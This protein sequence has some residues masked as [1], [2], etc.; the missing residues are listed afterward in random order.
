MEDQKLLS[1]KKAAK[2]LGVSERTIQRYRRDGILVPDQLGKNN[3]VFYSKEQ[4]IKVVT[5]LLA[6]GD[7]LIKFRPQVVTSYQQVVTS[8]ERAKKG[9]SIR[10][11]PAKKLVMVN[12]KLTKELFRHTPEEYLA[13]FEEGGE[14]VEVK[15]FPKVGEIITPYWLELIDE[16]TDKTPL[17]MF[18]KAVF[19]ACVSE[20][21]IGNRR[22]TDGIIFRHITGKPRGSNAQPS[23]AMRELILYY[24][25][26]MMCTVLRVNMTEVCKYL[27][28]NNGEPLILNAP[29]LP[30]KYVEEVINGQESR[31]VIYF[32]DESPLLTIA[33]VKNNQFLS[34]EPRLLNISNQSSSSRSISIRH[35]VIQRVLEIILHK[36]KPTIKFEYIFQVC[37][38]MNATSKEKYQAIHE[39]IEI[40]NYLANGSDILSFI[41]K[42]DGNDYQAIEFTFSQVVTSSEEKVVIS[43]DKLLSSGDKLTE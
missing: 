40:F 43:G 13:L 2:F 7:K 9:K 23:P 29:I 15:N 4:L 16:Y 18:A 28:Y 24:V 17:N 39:V 26:K 32:Y 6:G 21:I 22:T 20:W 5:R 38:L 36:L 3:S 37:G 12:D 11:I 30:C 10:L 35:C 27:N 33:R 1:T 41:V 42:K 8:S 34:V 25:R 19:T 31:A 14:I